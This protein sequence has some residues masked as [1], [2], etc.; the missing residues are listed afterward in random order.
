MKW[1]VLV[2]SALL[3]LLFGPCSLLPARANDENVYGAWRGQTQ[4][5]ETVSG[6]SNRLAHLI[7]PLTLTIEVGG[8]VAGAA[9]DS[10]CRIIGSTRPGPRPTMPDLDLTVSSCKERVFNRRY[11]GSLVLDAREQSATLRLRSLPPPL[12]GKPAIY[13]ISATLRR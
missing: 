5:R 6:G 12:F 8:T 11:T 9:G 4:F 1:T 3:C 13:D 7:A 2:T 10:G